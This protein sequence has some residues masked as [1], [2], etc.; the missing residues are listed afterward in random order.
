VSS[1]LLFLGKL[2]FRRGKSE[3]NYLFSHPFF[4]REESGKAGRIFFF[5]LTQQ[6]SRFSFDVTHHGTMALD[7]AP[8]GPR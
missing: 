3:D 1:F 7:D 8:N 5:Y 6:P 2:F 4:A